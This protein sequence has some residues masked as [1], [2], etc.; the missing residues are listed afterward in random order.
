MSKNDLGKLRK[1]VEKEVEE[2]GQA[3]FARA[4]D[5]P[6]SRLRN[7][8]EGRESRFQSVEALANAVGQ[9]VYI[10]APVDRKA[11]AAQGNQFG[12]RL[13]LLR[14]HVG[15][16]KVDLARRIQG[17]STTAIG[18][19]EDGKSSAPKPENL[20]A[21]AD[22]FEV[23]IIWLATGEGHISERT[24]NSGRAIRQ[25]RVKA[26]VPLSA[27]LKKSGLT[28]GD[29]QAVEA[30][31]LFDAPLKK[32]AAGLGVALKDVSNPMAVKNTVVPIH[33]ELLSELIALFLS[34]EGEDAQSAFL[35]Y[36]R[37]LSSDNDL[38]TTLGAG[39]GAA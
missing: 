29:W 12:K 4:N 23:S 31:S 22:V 14:T 5:L 20:V 24:L 34:I 28:L 16:T 9:E 21:L 18:L 11:I 35:E 8:L 15:W 30:G 6:L 1:L 13:K 27:I 33:S 3:Q 26:S 25:Q 2:V 17:L 10:G 37:I 39:A 7:F 19:L 36:C 32:V 38:E